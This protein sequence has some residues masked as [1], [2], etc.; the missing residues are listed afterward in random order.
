MGTLLKGED[1]IG[2]RVCDLRLVLQALPSCN[3]GIRIEDTP[4]LQR[5]EVGGTRLGIMLL[6][7][8]H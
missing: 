5:N 7:I 1:I 8:R 3:G 6:D 4:R 2:Q